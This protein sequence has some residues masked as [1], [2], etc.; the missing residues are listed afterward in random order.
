[1]RLWNGTHGDYAELFARLR[2]IVEIAECSKIIA[3]KIPKQLRLKTLDLTLQDEQCIELYAQLFTGDVI[4][5]LD[6]GESIFTARVDEIDSRAIKAFSS[7]EQAEVIIAKSPI[8]DFLAI[9]LDCLECRKKL[10]VSIWFSF[11]ALEKTIDSRCGVLEELIIL[12]I[13]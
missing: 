11:Q 7:E 6:Y 5:K 13:R 10:H 3:S 9:S 8:I 4:R 12:A 2:R 1:M